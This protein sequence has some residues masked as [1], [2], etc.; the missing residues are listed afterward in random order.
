MKKVR[1]TIEADEHFIRMLQATVQLS[2]ALDEDRPN[3]FTALKVLGVLALG[4][5]RGATEA[6]I[7]A[8]TPIEWRPHIEVIHDERKVTEI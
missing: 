3:Q 7:H 1:I 2:G 8:R 5:M 6:Q 4:E